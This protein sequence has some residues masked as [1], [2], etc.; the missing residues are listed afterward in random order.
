VFTAHEH[1]WCNRTLVLQFDFCRGL[2]ESDDGARQGIP[3]KLMHKERNDDDDDDDD[4][5]RL[6]SVEAIG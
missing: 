2:H 4:D 5:G 3:L 1:G 6:S